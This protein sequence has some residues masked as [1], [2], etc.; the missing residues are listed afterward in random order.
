MACLVI[1]LQFTIVVVHEAQIWNVILDDL[2]SK[3]ITKWHWFN[4]ISWRFEDVRGRKCW[5]VWWVHQ[6]FLQLACQVFMYNQHFPTCGNLSGYNT[7]GH[8][9]CPIHEEDTCHHQLQNGRKT[10]DRGNFNLFI[11]LF[12]MMNNKMCW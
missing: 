3:T 10:I 2:K 9:A 12:F 1:D 11:S 6:W 5:H 7:K 8:K 4:H